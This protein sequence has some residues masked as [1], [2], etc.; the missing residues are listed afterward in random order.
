MEEYVKTD[1][2]EIASGLNSV[3]SKYGSEVGYC[4]HGI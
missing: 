3:G 4:E 2:K 1:L